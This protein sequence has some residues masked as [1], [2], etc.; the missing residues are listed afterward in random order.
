NISPQKIQA[1]NK[2]LRRCSSSPIIRELQI[3]I[4]MRYHLMPTRI[5][6]IKKPENNKLSRMR[7]KRA[8]RAPWVGIENG[9]ALWKTVWRLLK[10]LK[11][12]LPHDRAMLPLGINPKE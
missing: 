4:T 6:T 5:T 3:K 2:R 12:E 1:A 9:A 8:P 10:T 11:T 7:K